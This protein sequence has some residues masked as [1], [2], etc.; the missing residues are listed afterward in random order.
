M[1]ILES[2][3]FQQD[4]KTVLT[5]IGALLIEKN[6]KYGNAALDPIRI[7]SKANSVEQLLVRIDDKLNR[8]KNQ[9]LDDDED[10]ITDL[11]GYLVLLKIAQKN[12][13]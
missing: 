8:L 10:A 9:Q 12:G 6:R 5:E 1:A 4:V 13:K 2:E 11:M 7:F 3:K